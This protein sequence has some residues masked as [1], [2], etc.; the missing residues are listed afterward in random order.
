[1]EVLE[2]R[3]NAGVG[4]GG[5]GVV[6]RGFGEKVIQREGGEER[7]R[8]ASRERASLERR[9]PED[10]NPPEERA[11]GRG[12]ARAQTIG[13]EQ[14]EELS[15]RMS[16]QDK[17]QADTD[18]RNRSKSRQ[19]KEDEKKRNEVKQRQLVERTE[20]IALSKQVEEEKEE[21]KPSS[22]ALI[23]IPE[24]GV[25]AL[26]KAENGLKAKEKTEREVTRVDD[27]GE[28]LSSRSG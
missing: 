4:G 24:A 18:I 26:P 27:E 1:M 21:F 28:I 23:S 5:Q 7:E 19:R 8:S 17:L 6:V 3:A 20:A 22:S 12:R 13:S 10:E 9:E 14:D 11:R 15:R 16:E 25:L 2:A